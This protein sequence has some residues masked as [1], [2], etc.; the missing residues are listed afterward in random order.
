MFA[1][2][3]IFF[4]YYGSTINVNHTKLSTLSTLSIFSLVFIS[5]ILSMVFFFI[6]SLVRSVTCS[7]LLLVLATLDYFC[8]DLLSFIVNY[9]F[10]FTFRPAATSNCPPFLSV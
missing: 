8:A 1:T 9:Y 4:D 3:S 10:I 7:K 5:S 2:L 6:D